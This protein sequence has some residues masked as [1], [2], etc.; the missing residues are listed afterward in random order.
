MPNAKAGR[1]Q[2]DINVYG[3]EGVPA[4]VIEER[5]VMKMT[6][7]RQKLEKD[8]LKLGIDLDDPKFNIKDYEIPNPRP[9]KRRPE[10]MGMMPPP[11]YY[12]PPMGMPPMGPPPPGYMRMPPPG[13]APPM[14]GGPPPPGA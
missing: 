11:M 1:D 4:E 10:M 3:M 7:K 6:K 12:P 2:V 14:M 8:L 9:P 5:L 13:M